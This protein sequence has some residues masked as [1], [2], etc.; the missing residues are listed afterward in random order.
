MEYSSDSS[1]MNLEVSDRKR[2]FRHDPSTCMNCCRVREKNI[3][4]AETGAISK[5]SKH[6]QKNSFIIIII[7][8][9]FVGSSVLETDPL[10]D[11]SGKFIL[12]ICIYFLFVLF[13]FTLLSRICVYFV[14]LLIF[15]LVLI[16][17]F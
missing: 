6:F 13:T 16:L 11:A 12:F 7:R 8:F 17:I 3:K 15:F 1:L 10:N 5:K 2:F 9:F 14:F 4:K